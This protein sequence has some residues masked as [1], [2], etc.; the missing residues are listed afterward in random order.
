MHITRIGCLSIKADDMANYLRRVH[1][2]VK[3]A[4]EDNNNKYKA[5][6]ERHRCKVTFK[7]GDLVWLILTCDRFPAGESNKIW[8]RN[9][10]PFEILPKINENI[11]RLHLPSHLKTSYMFNVKHLTPCFTNAD[12]DGLNL[13]ESSSQPGENDTRV[14]KNVEFSDSQCEGPILNRR[15]LASW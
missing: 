5:Q 15:Y 13:R 10:G 3:K 1:D 2:Q 9:I 14:T 12:S 11:H 6:S 8:E 4:I 7:V